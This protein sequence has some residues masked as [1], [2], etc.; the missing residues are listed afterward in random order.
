MH[1]RFGQKEFL[2]VELGFGGRVIQ[3]RQ[4]FLG[5][6]GS[7]LTRGEAHDQHVTQFVRG[8]P[9]Q[10]LDRAGSSPA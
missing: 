6:P 7:A 10:R 4:D 3:R 9:G 1:E 2:P 8:E 5:P